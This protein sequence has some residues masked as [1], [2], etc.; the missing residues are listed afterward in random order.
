M[1]SLDGGVSVPR[2][3]ELASREDANGTKAGLVGPT[4]SRKRAREWGLVLSSQ[5]I[6]HTL[7]FTM[8]GWVLCVDGSRHDDATNAIAE[9][10]RENVA[11]PP[12]RERTRPR[13]A[14]TLS[15]L[16]AFL[17]VAAFHFAITGDATS[18]SRWFALGRADSR[19]LVS[20]PWRVVTALTLHA[21]APHVLGNVVSGTI[22]GTALARTIG[23][24]AALLAIVGS[25][26]IGNALNAFSYGVIARDVHRSIGS[27]TAV[28]AT[29]GLLAGLE[30]VRLVR[31]RSS[32]EARPMRRFVEILG[33]VVGGLALLGSLGASADSDLGAHGYGIL[34]GFLVGVSIAVA[35]KRHAEPPGRPNHA[36]QRTLAFLGAALVAGCWALALS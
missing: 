29:I 11:W 20:E 23:P 30:L 36:L 34:A 12:V 3:A 24:G 17:C 6:A 13:Y 15:V 33:P 35:R 26:A 19:L 1:S 25:G 9:Y 22:F 27:S 18:M 2:L 32:H 31:A 14:R 4:D 8:D 21:D 10:E 5:G 16:F 28:F 7:R